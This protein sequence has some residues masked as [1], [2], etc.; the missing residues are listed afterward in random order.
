MLRATLAAFVISQLATV[1][2]DAFVFPRARGAAVAGLFYPIAFLLYS[3]FS[4]RVASV[5]QKNDWEVC[6]KAPKE[7][8]WGTRREARTPFSP[9]RLRR[10]GGFAKPAKLAGSLKRVVT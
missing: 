2:I 9:C 5:F 7:P 1:L 6:P 4:E 10:E 3:L 8:G